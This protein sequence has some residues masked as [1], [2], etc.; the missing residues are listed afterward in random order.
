[1]ADDEAGIH[2][3]SEPARDFY[4]LPEARQKRLAAYLNGQLAELAASG[5]GSKEGCSG[6]WEPGWAVYWDVNLKPMYRGP[7]RK[8]VPSSPPRKLGTYYRIEVLEIGRV[9]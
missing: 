5:G 6:V 9:P 3:P 8:R 4:K 7:S 2:W 1:M